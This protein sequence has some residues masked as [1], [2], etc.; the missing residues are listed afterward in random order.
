MTAGRNFI[1]PYQLVRLIRS[2][3]KTQVWEA[4]DQGDRKR[5]ALKILQRDFRA[6]KDQIAELKHELAVGKTLEHDNVIRIFDYYDQHGL[7][8]LAMQLFN[9]RNLKIEMRENLVYVAQNAREI[10]VQ[11]AKGLQHLHEKSWIHCDVKPDN[12]LLDPESN[13]VKLIDFSIAEKAKKG[14]GALFGG[15]AKTIRGTRSYMSPEQ[16]RKKKLDVRADIYGLG[17]MFFEMLATRAPFTAP[18]SDDLL[19]KHLR[20]AIPSLEA[21]SGAS[22]NFSDLVTRML[23]KEPSERP[24][25]MKQIALELSRM[26]VYRPGKIPR[27]KDDEERDD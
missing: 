15:G 5:V 7:P 25:S 26:Q 11:C 17:C 6:D 1:G 27:K 3:T 10:M 13:A 22:K 4:L 9:A 24:D 14:L 2:G 8:L 12:F 21:C 20:S 16:I 19:N 23:A 18:N